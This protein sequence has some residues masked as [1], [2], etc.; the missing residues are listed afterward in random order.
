MNKKYFFL[1]CISLL[2]W[3][4]ALNAQTQQPDRNR[5]IA[6]RM[7]DTLALSEEQQDK[8]YAI[9]VQ[10]DNVKLAYYKQHGQTSSLRANMQKIESSRDSLYKPVLTEQQFLLYRQKKYLLVN[11]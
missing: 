4:C 6:Q 2:G 11:P 7:K 5:I 3:C 9:N 1:T 10:M 8:I